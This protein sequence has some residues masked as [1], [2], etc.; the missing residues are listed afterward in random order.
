MEVRK[1]RRGAGACVSQWTR[2]VRSAMHDVL[3]TV[4]ITIYFEVLVYVQL[5]EDD[6]REAT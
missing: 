3:T 4:S 1:L 5:Y 6:A 2:A